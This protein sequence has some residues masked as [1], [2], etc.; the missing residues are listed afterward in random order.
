VRSFHLF[1][2]ALTP[3]KLSVA[4]NL[5]DVLERLRVLLLKLKNSFYDAHIA[6]I[7]SAMGEMSPLV[8]VRFEAVFY[9]PTALFFWL[10]WF[11]IT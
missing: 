9:T 7:G 10:V 2:F 1:D 3:Q 8:G 5:N 11:E 6:L 4:A